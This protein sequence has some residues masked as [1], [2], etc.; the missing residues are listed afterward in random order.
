VGADGIGR[1]VGAFALS[2][3]GR[4]QAL[5]RRVGH[6][7]SDEIEQADGQTSLS[8]GRRAGRPFVQLAV[9][10][11][12]PFAAEFV[13]P[14]D[15][16]EFRLD[17]GQSQRGTVRSV[18]ISGLLARKLIGPTGHSQSMLGLFQHY[19]YED[20]SPFQLGQQSVSGAFL[21]QRRLGERTQIE[22]S[23][24]LEAVLLGAISS[25]HGFE[26]RR[27]YDLGP[28]A[29]LRLG[30]SFTRDGQDWV[31]M[32]RRTVWLHSLHGSGGSHVASVVRLAAALPV[33]GAL[34][35]GGDVVSMTRHSVYPDFPS[36]NQQTPEVRAYLT[37]AR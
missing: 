26:W 10:Y 20:L 2:P 15:A 35:V 13:R 33:R 9:R 4:T 25:D 6:L 8:L 28:G 37:W 19:D 29:G 34:S 24:H 30:A 27:D 32:E 22:V 5:M 23:A 11:R 14:Y 18:E 21:H 3:L 12:D 36:V 17:L 1:E 31:R 7:P 16:F